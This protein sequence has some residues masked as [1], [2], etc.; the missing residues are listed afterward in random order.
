MGLR[1]RHWESRSLADNPQD[2]KAN[3]AIQK[4]LLLISL[5]ALFCELLV[6]RWLSTEIRVFAY[7]KNLPLMSAF[8]GL[9]LG[10]IWSNRKWSLYRWS[11]YGLMLLLGLLI[12]AFKLGITYLTFVN[13]ADF[14]LFGLQGEAGSDLAGT[15]RSLAIMVSVF[16]LSTSIFVGFGQK[17]GKLFEQ[18]SPLRGYSVN[19][20][21]S[22]LGTLLFSLLCF[23]SL[24]PAYWMVCA[25][26]LFFAVGL[27]A[28]ASGLALVGVLYGLWLGPYIT[29]FTYG[30]EYVRTEWSPYYRIDV[31]RQT[32]PAGEFKGSPLGYNIYINYDSF[33]SIVDC[34]PKNL[35]KFPPQVAEAMLLEVAVP[36]KAMSKPGQEVLVL[37]SGSGS[38]VAAALRNGAGHVDAVEIDPVIARLGRE[39]HPEKPYSS[40]KVDLYVTDARNFL[41]NCKKKYDIIVFAA[42]DSHAAFSSL[43]SLRM[44]NYVF[45]QESLDQATRLLTDDGIISVSFVIPADWLWKRHARALA[46]AT[47]TTPLGFREDAEQSWGLLLAGPG[48]PAMDNL[49]PVLAAKHTKPVAIDETVNVAT[50]DWPFLFLPRREVPGLYILPILAVLLIS[51]IPVSMEFVSGGK[52]ILN[53][54]MFT[55]GAAFMLLEVRAMA[56][57]SLI[58]GSTWIVNSVIIS[59]VMIVILIANW[60]ASKIEQK[61]VYLMLAGV[62]LA[63]L[64]TT[65]VSS[66]S[67]SSMGPVAGGLVGTVLFLFPLV[68]ASTVFALLFKA[69]KSP[70]NALAFNLIG[71]LLGVCLEYLSMA[72][73]IRALGWIGIGLYAVVLLLNLVRRPVRPATPGSTLAGASGGTGTEMPVEA[74]ASSAEKEL[75]QVQSSEGQLPG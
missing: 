28:P 8:L 5:L 23:L 61:H 46:E 52:D 6:I 65:F 66:A 44:D 51:V 70:S 55:L 41:K 2:K 38:D 27:R 25:A 53:W 49:P 36:F 21:G 32:V 37:G 50:D 73:G 9:G 63:L 18:L 11:G 57:L 56:D 19:V 24:S 75:D 20:L 22:L 31:A 69:T 42:L 68:F 58:Y 47:G 17:M 59:G 54:Q 74:T 30:G 16:I 64:L 39:L 33:Q 40:D 13:P 67:F 62:L 15:V 4:E 48:M 43:S 10:F 3:F 35:E 29:H 34:T 72:L 14:M 60:V 45:T 1:V 26:L 71:G 12:C 7:F